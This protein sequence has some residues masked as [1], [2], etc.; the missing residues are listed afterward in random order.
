MSLR[1]QPRERARTGAAGMTGRARP[2]LVASALGVSCLASPAPAW[3]HG[4]EVAIAD[5][6]SAWT[7]PPAVLA[8]AGVLL[9]LFLQGWVRL[10]RR[11]RRDHAPLW[12]LACFGAALA[13]GVLPL[14]SPLDAVA[15]EYLLSAHMLEHVL[16]ADAAVA[17]ALVAVGGPLLF[18]MLPR[19]ATLA[20]GRSAGLRRALRA[21]DHPVVALAVWCAVI[22]VWH[23]PSLYDATLENG[24]VHDLEHASFV[25]AGLLMWYQ[26]LDPARKGHVSR[27][28]RLGLAA[29]MLAAGQALSAVLLFATRPLYPAYAGQD[30]RLWGISALADQRYAGAV[31]MVEQ[32]AVIGAFTLFLLLAA[33]T[34]E[35]SVARE[36]PAVPLGRKT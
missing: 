4:D 25:A 27:G 13:L 22:A 2:L 35:S 19:R 8:A 12:R 16:I 6:P 28:R 18:F 26:L 20:A 24:A 31:M 32:A 23:V 1:A 15:E 21:L 14:V 7:A 10:R 29:G 11:G 34:A 36:R 9:V 3:A 17:L 33:D 30:E 5:L